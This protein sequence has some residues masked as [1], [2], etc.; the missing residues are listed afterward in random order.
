[1]Q[2]RRPYRS[3]YILSHHN[4]GTL[5][6][7]PGPHFHRWD[8]QQFAHPLC[9]PCNSG[10][11]ERWHQCVTCPSSSSRQAPVSSSI[12]SLH[13]PYGRCAVPVGHHTE[14]SARQPPYQAEMRHPVNAGIT[15]QIP[16]INAGQ[17]SATERHSGGTHKRFI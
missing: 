8:I 16:E 7:T 2:C 6:D 11:A 14:Q 3:G 9:I 12:K 17:R 1:M 15:A 4:V 13:T 5:S 10:K